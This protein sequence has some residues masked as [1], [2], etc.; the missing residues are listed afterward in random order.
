LARERYSHFMATGTDANVFEYVDYRAFL[1]DFYRA[2][3]DKK[4]PLSLRAFAKRAGT[5]SYNYLSLVMKGERNLSPEMAVRFARGC[6]LGKAEADYFCELVS[7]GQARTAEQRN[8]CYERL[9]RFRQFRATHKLE[10]AQA[11]YH[12]A[13]YMPAIRELVALPDFKSDPKWIASRLTPPISPAQAR[14]ALGTL[15]ALGLLVRDGHGHVRQADRLVTTGAGPLGHHVVNFHHAMITQAARALDDMP[16]DERDISA[17]TLGVSERSLSRLKERI[18][19]FRQELL[20]LAELDGPPERVVQVNFQM[21]PLT[22]ANG[23][24]R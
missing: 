4:R 20:Q 1:R 7:F 22:I 11:A 18:A 9:G 16:R 23:E 24:E 17:L 14:D 5:R 8:R 21:F 3:K 19:A 12:S 13:W 6:G 2:Q 10:P 15:C